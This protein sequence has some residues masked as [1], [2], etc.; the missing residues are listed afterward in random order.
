M[1]KI[2]VLMFFIFVLTGCGNQG[3]INQG[4]QE[5]ANADFSLKYPDNWEIFDSQ[6]P[7]G[8]GVGFIAKENPA[9]PE[10]IKG[11]SIVVTD[12]KTTEIAAHYQANLTAMAE[13]GTQLGELQQKPTTLSGQSAVELI[14]PSESGTES[15][16]IVA[17]K[18]DRTYLIDYEPSDEIQKEI[19]QS[20]K[21][22]N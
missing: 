18:N 15:F 10:T 9:K 5:Y 3:Q 14:V 21:F 17:E 8:Q 6:T 13:Q 1:K 2:L 4:W 22:E 11:L 12:K 20:F 7:F 19:I 16:Y